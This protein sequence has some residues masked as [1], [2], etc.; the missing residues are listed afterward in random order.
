MVARVGSPAS[1]AISAN[2]AV[3]ATGKSVL[4]VASAYRAGAANASICAEAFL[5]I[6]LQSDRPITATMNRS[7][8]NKHI[9][10]FYGW[11][12][13]QGG[14]VLALFGWGLGFYGPPVFLSIVSDSHGWSVVLISSAISLHFLVGSLIGANLPRLHRR[15][16]TSAVTKAGGLSMAAGI[17]GW[18][19]ASSP[20][21]LFVTA[22]LSGAGW[23][24]MS[25]AAL[26]SIVSPWF[27]RGRPAALGM[28]YNGG[29][30]GGIVFSP[31]WVTATGALGFPVAASAIAIL[32]VV[33][34]W[35]LADAVF[36]KTPDTIGVRPDGDQAGAPTVSV[37]SAEAKPLPGAMLWSDRQFLTL[38]TAMALGL[39][40]QIGLIAHLFSLLVPALGAQQAGLAMALVTAMA[41]A[42]RTLLGRLMPLGADRRMVGCAGYLAQAAGCLVLMAAGGSDVALLLAG[43]VLF[44]VGFG[45]AT[46]LPPLIA[47]VEFVKDDVP[48]VAALIVALSQAGY[49]VAPAFF[50]LIRELTPSASMESGEAPAVF[51][52]AALVQFL[53]IAALLSGRGR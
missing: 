45:N 22:T 16:G 19:L 3:V 20:W 10:T 7:V 29:S 50:G 1:E 31:L 47:Q 12:V 9:G 32:T 44:G 17:C 46:S 14:F 36:A 2:W 28:A 52:T 23:G 5:P 21:H 41:I 42:G 30:V 37:T 8:S 33:V 27:V 40:A 38:A 35:I 39:F 53:A 24:T 4:S 13:V 48:R 15:F 25:A 34:V 51:A 11:R 43:I 49:A 6:S 18:A 26:N